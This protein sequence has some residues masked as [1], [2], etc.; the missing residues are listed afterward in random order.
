MT[1]ELNKDFFDDLHKLLTHYGF[2]NVD[3]SSMSVNMDGSQGYNINGVRTD[4][5]SINFF[6][7]LSVVDQA[8]E[9]AAL[10]SKV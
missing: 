7:E 8:E 1:L 9:L 6:T 3:K 5:W 4:A 2:K 10:K